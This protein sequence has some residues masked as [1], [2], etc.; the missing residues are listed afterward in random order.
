M[1]DIITHQHLSGLVE[2]LDYYIQ[3]PLAIMILYNVISALS[4]AANILHL[5]IITAMKRLGR[6][7]DLPKTYKSFLI[8]LA[9]SDLIGSLWRLVSANEMTQNLLLWSRACCVFSAV[10]IHTCILTGSSCMLL[11]CIDRVIASR[12]KS[13]YHKRFYVKHFTKLLAIIL[14]LTVGFHCTIAGVF[15]R[16]GYRV[17]GLGA[18][19]VESEKVPYLRWITPSIIG[20]ELIV[21]V[22]CYGTL[23][24]Q[25]ATSSSKTVRI[26][27][28]ITKRIAVVKRFMGLLILAKIVAWCPTTMTIVIRALKVNCCHILEWIG[29][30]TL[31]SNPLIHPLIYG[32]NNRFYA[33]FV[34]GMRRKCINVTKTRGTSKR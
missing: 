27:R 16:K 24:R 12:G 18:C 29:I 22:S 19:I 8:L 20:I 14:M 7:N 4:V 1:E 5:Y 3:P 25:S 13:S 9:T 11:I 34:S 21:I 23:L 28:H 15:S 6:R 26:A 30:V 10:L 33:R 2:G 32:L 31:I 17:K